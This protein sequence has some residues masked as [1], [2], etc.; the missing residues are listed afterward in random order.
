MKI[1]NKTFWILA[2][3]LCSMTHNLY[4]D[5]IGVL[6]MATGKYIK[7]VPQ[8]VKSAETYFCPGHEV[9]FYVFTDQEPPVLE[10]TV[11]IHQDRL[12]WPF[13]TMMR[14]KIYYQNRSSYA[15]EN[16]IFALDADMLFV[17]HVGDEVLGKLVGTI[18]PGFWNKPTATYENRKTS[19]AYVNAK[20]AKHYFA[21]GFF[22]GSKDEMLKLFRTTAQ[23]VEKDLKQNIIAIWHDESHLNRYFFD[24]EPDVIL[25]PSYCYPEHL[26][27]PFKRKLLALL[28][29][30]EDCRK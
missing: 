3:F 30:H 28:K 1:S 5:N 29:N 8:L 12:G 21:G 13:D 2:I 7:F 4:C 9:T 17:D 19:N 24:H 14:N 11:F 15:K 25:S 26:E 22:G 23:N 18:H 10:Q 6:V 16:Y 20:K 27:I